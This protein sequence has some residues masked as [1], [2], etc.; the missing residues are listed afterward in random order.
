MCVC[1]SVC[2][3]VCVSEDRDGLMPLDMPVDDTLIESVADNEGNCL[4]TDMGKVDNVG[5]LLDTGM[6]KV[7]NEG[8]VGPQD[9]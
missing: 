5:N 8:I 6:G 4:D 1:L 7:A 2:L 3:C 9:R